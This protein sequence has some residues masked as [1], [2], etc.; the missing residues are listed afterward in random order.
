MTT[1]RVFRLHLSALLPCEWWGRKFLNDSNIEAVLIKRQPG[2][3]PRTTKD[4]LKVL[5]VVVYYQHSSVKEVNKLTV[6][7]SI[8]LAK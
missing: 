7:D 5:I 4:T 8:R 6:F 3:S 2:D 1:L